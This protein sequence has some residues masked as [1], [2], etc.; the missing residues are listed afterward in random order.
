M[1]LLDLFNN[2]FKQDI[3]PKRVKDPKEN[4]PVPINVELPSIAEATGFKIEPLTDDKGQVGLFNALPEKVAENAVKYPIWATDLPGYE[5]Q[6]A[7]FNTETHTY[8]LKLADGTLGEALVLP[9]SPPSDFVKQSFL[10]AMTNAPSVPCEDPNVVK[11]NF[12]RDGNNEIKFEENPKGRWSLE[13]SDGKERETKKPPFMGMAYDPAN[14]FENINYKPT[15]E[16]SFDGKKIDNSIDEAGMMPKPEIRFVDP[17][18]PPENE[19]TRQG[20][21][22]RRKMTKKEIEKELGFELPTEP[23]TDYIRNAEFYIKASKMHE[24]P[25]VE[26]YKNRL[27]KFEY[28]R[29]VYNLPLPPESDV[30]LFL[31][32]Y[33]ERIEDILEQ[34]IAHGDATEIEPYG[35]MLRAVNNHN[36][37][38][39]YE[40]EIDHRFK[41]F[42]GKLYYIDIDNKVKLPKDFLSVSVVGVDDKGKKIYF[43]KESN[44]KEEVYIK[45]KEKGF[46]PNF[47]PM[48]DKALGQAEPNPMYVAGIDPYKPKLY[49]AIDPGKSGGISAVDEH[50]KVVSMQEMPLFGNQI[51][52]LD[53]YHQLMNFT[54]NY[55]CV[56]TIEDVHS[57]YGTSSNS[58]WIF[59]FGCGQVD[60]V[61]SLT[62]IKRYSIQPKAWQKNIWSNPDMVYKPLKIGQK[63]PSVDTKPTSLNAAKRL[64]P[65]EDLRGHIEIKYYGNTP[66]NRKLK[67]VGEPIPTKK[68][69]AHDGIVDSLLIA[70]CSRR[71]NY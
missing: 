39:H 28:E 63:K 7:I 59:G 47:T 30:A 53:L 66:E 9:H 61:I 19:S 44:A 31:D 2:S 56:I 49:I 64:F 36:R 60:A 38:F 6:V 11:G 48:L 34:L 1:S 4:I 20:A 32:S 8:H 50:G 12:V 26:D 3:K 58:N 65:T 18:E 51:D 37:F 27:T 70:E 42:N 16:A 15:T 71:L 54:V 14:D 21:I 33:D 55:N 62:K 22:K 17:I 13:K 25:S 23:N 35:L 41:R 46:A 69:N 43:D 52:S 57:I 10:G 5:G 68:N 45:S 67:R 40:K 29:E 24:R